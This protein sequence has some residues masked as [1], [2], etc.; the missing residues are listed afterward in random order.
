M[1]VQCI[2]YYSQ[3]LEIVS[4]SYFT[5]K[6]SGVYSASNLNFQLGDVG[7]WNAIVVV[8]DRSFLFYSEISAGRVRL[9]I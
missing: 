7:W 4:E 2:I 5:N 1:V 8:F 6:T 3:N 9:V